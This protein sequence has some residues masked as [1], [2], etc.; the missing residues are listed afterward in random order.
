M[1]KDIRSLTGGYLKFNLKVSTLSGFES[2][3]KING[4]TSV[5]HFELF[6]DSFH[7]NFKSI[8]LETL[9][10]ARAK[11]II[12]PQ[13]LTTIKV[14]FSCLRSVKELADADLQVSGL[15][16]MSLFII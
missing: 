7:L 14:V 15:C 12:K 1:N 10:S 4:E 9:A 11:R 2:T 6:M 8:F 3:E 16:P 5:F 13:T